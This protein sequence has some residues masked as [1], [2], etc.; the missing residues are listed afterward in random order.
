M[1]ASPF[2]RIGRFAIAAL[3]AIGLASCGINSV[4]AAEETAKAKWADVE[5]AYQ[6]RANLLQNLPE[7][8]RAAGEREQEILTQVVDARAR[9]TSVNVSA[10]DLDDPV[11]ME[12]FAQ[13]QGQLSAGIGRLLVAVEAYPELQSIVN[14]QMLQSQIEGQ[15]NRIRIA[16]RDYNEAVRE[17]NTTIRTFPDVIG[18]KIIHGADPLVPYSAV[19]PGAET[20]ENLE[21]RL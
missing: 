16:I 10:D 3:A 1:N 12:A 11:A 20:A 4:P 14:Y 18:A 15:E 8:V 17:Y 6:E 19:T 5:A 9:A 13:A 21:G 7:V 2:A